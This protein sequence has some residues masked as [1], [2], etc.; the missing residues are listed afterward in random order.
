[1]TTSQE[2][3]TRPSADP[4]KGAEVE[5]K[6]AINDAFED[7]IAAITS[8]AVAES[9]KIAA[10]SVLRRLLQTAAVGTVLSPAAV[11]YLLSK[12]FRPA[13]T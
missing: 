10:R 1:M 6:K 9:E 7:V 4:S 11:E 5:Q 12:Y 2:A 3:E 8:A 13:N